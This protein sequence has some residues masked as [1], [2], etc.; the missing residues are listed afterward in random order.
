[1]EDLNTI[2][3]WILF[4]VSPPASGSPAFIRTDVNGD[5]AIGMADLNL[6]VDYLLA[7]ITRFPV[8]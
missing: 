4:R 8:E 1:M 3:D 2:V 6:L 5:G 7:R